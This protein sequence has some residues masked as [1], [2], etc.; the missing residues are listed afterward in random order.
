[1]KMRHWIGIPILS[2]LL[3]L[4]FWYGCSI[5]SLPTYH[6]S[7]YAQLIEIAVVASESSCKPEETAQLAKLSTHIVFYS[8]YLPNN[9]HVAQGVVEMDKSIQALKLAAPDSAYCH[10]KLRAITSMATTL[11]DVAGSKTK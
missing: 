7:E 10:L 3:I 5:I 6:E 1:M 4:P 2:L 9:E 8:E 11:A